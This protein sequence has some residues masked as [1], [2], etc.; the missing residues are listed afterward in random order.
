MYIGSGAKGGDRVSFRRM[1]YDYIVIYFFR[2]LTN[3]VLK[4]AA[5]SAQA[6]V[7]RMHAA[8]QTVRRSPAEPVVRVVRRATAAGGRKI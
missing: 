4:K 7:E 3:F 2:F 1:T 8:Y 6:D 5:S